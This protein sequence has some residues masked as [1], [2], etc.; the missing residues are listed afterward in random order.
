M[1]ARLYGGRWNSEGNSMVYSS[2][3]ASLAL[4]EFVCNSN[5]LITPKNIGLAELSLPETAEIQQISRNELPANWDKYPA[6]LFLKNLGDNW[7]KENKSV[8]LKVPSAIMP[9]QQNVLLNPAHK[10]FKIINFNLIID[11]NFDKRLILSS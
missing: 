3:S 10:D 11:F 7:L 5:S 6:P 8:A 9:I 1:G 4:L 2:M